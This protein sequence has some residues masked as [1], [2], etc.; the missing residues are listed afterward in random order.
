MVV[1]LILAL[2]IALVAV[3]FALQNLIPVT[4][5]FL[6]WDFNAS[7]A[8][9]ILI[10]LLLGVLIGY[11]ATV[12]GAIRGK[13]A[14]NAQKKKWQAAEDNSAKMQMRI[15]EAEKRVANAEQKAIEAEASVRRKQEELA[16]F[17]AE[18]ERSHEEA[19]KQATN[20][21]PTSTDTYQQPPADPT[22]P[23]STK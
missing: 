11:L 7:L 19:I 10:T 9:V 5:T 22:L 21:L 15:D 20:S 17:T 4:V 1:F 12:P 8:L 2:L 3:V 23:P 16:T 6:A 14:A 18:I 13:I